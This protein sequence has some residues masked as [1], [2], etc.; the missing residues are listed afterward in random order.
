[1][2][3]VAGAGNDGDGMNQPL[4]PAACAGVVAVGAVNSSGRPWRKTERQHYVTVAAPGVGI[5]WVGT[6]RRYYPDGAGTSA[7][8]ALTSGA[9][10][11]VRAAH[12]DWR[13]RTIVQRMIATASPTGRRDQSGYGI[14]RVNRVIDPKYRVSANAPDPVY[15][16]LDR[17]AARN[18]RP[19]PSTASTA[20]RPAAE[21]DHDTSSPDLFLIGGALILG[22]AGAGC[23]AALMT[24]GRNTR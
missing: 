1:M 2:V 8:A 11:L 4:F 23:L 24:R 16:R 7:A 9:L 12:P 15:Q 5:G 18:G 20:T 10:A 21:G 6:D 17:W 19:K 3:I 13:A 22:L 14:F